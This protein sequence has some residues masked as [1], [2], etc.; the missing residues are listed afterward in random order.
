MASLTRTEAEIRPEDEQRARRVVVEL[1]RRPLR[2]HPGRGTVIV[3]APAHA[4]IACRVRRRSR[5]ARVRGV[6]G[7]LVLTAVAV[8]ALGLLAQLRGVGDGPDVPEAVSVVEV[9]PGESLW[10]LARRVAPDSPSGAVID[11]IVE[12]N[13]LSDHVVYP[14]QPLRVPDGRARS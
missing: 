11:R 1:H 12:L 4:V 3:P 10:Q 2:R 9:D 8:V 7:A 13:E 5:A 6:L 14:G